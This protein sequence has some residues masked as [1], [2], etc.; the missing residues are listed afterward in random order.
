M[1]KRDSLVRD[2]RRVG[3]L[4]AVASKCKCAACYEQPAAPLGPPILT[5]VQMRDV[6]LI[7]RLFVPLPPD[8]DPDPDYG[9]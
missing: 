8:S 9:F 6:A 7:D 3:A 4:T 1:S 2:F 5:A